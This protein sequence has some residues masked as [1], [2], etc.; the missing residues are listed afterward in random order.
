M[1]TTHIKLAEKYNYLEDRFVKAFEFLRRE[2]LA[3]LEAG[4]YPID[5]DVIIANVQHYT[6]MDAFT[7]QYETHEKFFDVQYVIEGQEQF[8][9]VSREGL[10]AITD[11][12]TQNDITFYKEPAQSGSVVLKSG[13]FVIVAP[14]DA[15]KPRCISGEA[16]AVK[17][18]V[19]KVRV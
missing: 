16:C 17:K 8:G 1:F 14:E 9:C 12:D 18:I 13:D 2:D 6:T 7:L 19:I 10:T 5:G 15:H 11:Y 3:Q 4:A